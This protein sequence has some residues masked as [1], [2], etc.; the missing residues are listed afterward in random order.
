[1]T[2]A[3]RDRFVCGLRSKKIQKKLLTEEYSFD[4]ALKTALSFEVAVKDVAEFKSEANPLTST[5]VNKLGTVRHRS[6]RKPRPNSKPPAAKEC[7]P[8]SIY[9]QIQQFF[10]PLLRKIR[11]HSCR[12]QERK[13]KNSPGCREKL[14]PGSRE[15]LLG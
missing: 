3:L 8:S 11:T 12:M 1:M 9:M 7:R 10:L 13:T 6:P 14:A 15:L 2:E 5:P 4:E